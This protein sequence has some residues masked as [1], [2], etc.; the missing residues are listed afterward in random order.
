M[1]GARALGIK[2]EVIFFQTCCARLTKERDKASFILH[3]SFASGTQVSDKE[4]RFYAEAKRTP[5]VLEPLAPLIAVIPF[6]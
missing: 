4:G 3:L 5:V 1:A 6:V 2:Q